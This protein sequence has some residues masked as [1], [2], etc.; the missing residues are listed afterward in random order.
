MQEYQS[1][2]ENRNMI[3]KI[4]TNAV[5]PH[6]I[7]HEE[8]HRHILRGLASGTSLDAEGDRMSEKALRAMER[9][10]I[11]LTLHKDHVFKVDNTLGHFI[12]AKILS[13]STG[14]IH[15][16][17]VEAELEPFD[18][19][20]DAKT[21]YEKIKSGTR[22]G[23]SVAGLI[24]KWEKLE[25]NEG[26]ERFLITDIELLS[27]DLVTVPAYRASQGSIMA[28][29]DVSKSERSTEDAVY[30]CKEIGEI[31]RNP[32]NPVEN[33]FPDKANR[34][35]KNL[36]T[37]ITDMESLINKL[38]EKLNS[39]TEKGVSLSGM[40]EIIRQRLARIEANI[41]EPPK[42][43][44]IMITRDGRET[45]LKDDT[46]DFEKGAVRIL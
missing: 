41:V 6:L 3:F 29:D 24:K 31:L 34:C 9:Q 10:I 12:G 4:Y 36:E 2:M 39:E 1:R 13:D 38:D 22:L 18:I 15:E 28:L 45:V 37:K 5:E 17:M 21:V 7:Q 35:M 20:P 30:I 33:D 43:R 8:T 46:E 32:I 11:G 25:S 42:S 26:R 16:L 14:N 23:F 27:V 40:L 44:G 19:N